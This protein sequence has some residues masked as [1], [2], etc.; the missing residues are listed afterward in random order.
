MN[1]A[2]D[3]QRASLKVETTD[4]II[5]LRD[6]GPDVKVMNMTPYCYV[7]LKDHERCDPLFPNPRKKSRTSDNSEYE[8][9]PTVTFSIVTKFHPTLFLKFSIHGKF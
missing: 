8:K 1:I 7:Y 6:N 3:A 4:H 5:R 2:K 9:S